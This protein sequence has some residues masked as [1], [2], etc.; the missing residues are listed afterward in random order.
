[1]T[2][3]LP[4]HVPGEN[5]GKKRDI[6]AKASNHASKRVRACDD[7]CAAVRVRAGVRQCVRV[8]ARTRAA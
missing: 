2:L 7:A 1:M 5:K 4:Q 8:R 3:H 6:E